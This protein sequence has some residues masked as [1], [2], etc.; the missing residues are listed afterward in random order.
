VGSLATFR[1]V[2]PS[3]LNIPADSWICPNIW[4]LGLRASETYRRCTDPEGCLSALRSRILKGGQW[5]INKSMFCGIWFQIT[6]S[7]CRLY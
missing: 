5:V 1:K 3:T 6:F 4:Y 7:R 2:T